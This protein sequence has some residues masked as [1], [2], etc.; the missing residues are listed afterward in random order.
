MDI[1]E[2]LKKAA[3]NVL[4]E[5]TL[6]AIETAFNT[7]VNTKADSKAKERVT[8]E[9]EN[10]LTNLDDQHATKLEKLL[11]AI[12]TDHVHKL[13]AVVK[14]LDENHSNKLIWLVKRYRGQM[15][16][17]ATKLRDTLI[18]QISNY[19]DL[20]LDKSIPTQ[21]VTEAVKNTRAQK[22][23]NAIKRVLVVDSSFITKEVKE[24][25]LDGKSKINSLQKQLNQTIQ[26]NVD[27]NQTAR[28]QKQN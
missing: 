24:A 8:L 2:L 26:E 4:T 1:K 12:D 5:E 7:A 18:D 11:E 25:L 15:Q 13:K 10:A 16:T 9:V 20:Y 14:K 3:G 21:Q 27:L 22:M 28:K 19:L 6:T 23:V 17:E